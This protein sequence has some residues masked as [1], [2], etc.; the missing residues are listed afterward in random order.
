MYSL[1]KGATVTEHVMDLERRRRPFFSG[2]LS[3][4]T[5]R[6]AER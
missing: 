5:S 3:V 4:L 1:P 6:K 2:N